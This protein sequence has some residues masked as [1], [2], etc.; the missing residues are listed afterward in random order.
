MS[1]RRSWAKG[2]GSTEE[3]FSESITAGQTGLSSVEVLKEQ[4]LQ[5]K[6]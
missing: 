4:R 6:Q 3:A 1:L 5:L 2:H